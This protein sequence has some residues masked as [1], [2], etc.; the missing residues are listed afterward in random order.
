[1]NCQ[2]FEDV[3]G[4]L[5]RG[6]MMETYLRSTALSHLDDCVRCSQRFRDEQALM[7]GLH[8][9]SVQMS[10]VGASTEV[11]TRL[12][13]AMRAS[14]VPPPAVAKVSPR[15]LYWLAVAAAVVVFIGSI[16]AASWQW[17]SKGNKSVPVESAVKDESPKSS[18]PNKQAV[19]RN[20]ETPK[21]AKPVIRRSRSTVA[22][23]RG[24]RAAET[25]A[26]HASEIATDFIPLGNI[27]ST[28]LQE[29]GTIVRVE[30]PRSALV[31]FG[32]PVNMDRVNENVK[33]DVWLGVD[34]LAHAIRFVH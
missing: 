10:S 3:V 28:S 27:N 2:K 18:Q 14:L 12:R 34:G 23:R 5:A 4:D 17:Q 7:R 16:L 15:R 31:R 25:V 21:T 22:T 11:E 19:V 20:A 1:M 33:A 8:A 29:G 9:L 26:N 13:E 30:L 32:L 24:P 6:Q